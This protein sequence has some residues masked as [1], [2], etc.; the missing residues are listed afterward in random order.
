MNY[1]ISNK[2]RAIRETEVEKFV[3]SFKTR[4]IDLDTDQSAIKTLTPITN[5]NFLFQLQ[6]KANLALLFISLMDEPLYTILVIKRS[7]FYGTSLMAF[8]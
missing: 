4:K 5:W 8:I 1:W 7:S 2:H 6:S 3:S